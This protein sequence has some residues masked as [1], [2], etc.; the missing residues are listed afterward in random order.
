V[1]VFL[2]CRVELGFRRALR[3]AL[4]RFAFFTN[5]PF[6][7]VRALNWEATCGTLDL[8]QGQPSKR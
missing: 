6:S 5:P 1:M 4:G 7:S 3:P 2:C 8:I